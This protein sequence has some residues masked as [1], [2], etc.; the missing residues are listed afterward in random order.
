M[1]QGER[2]EFVGGMESISKLQATLFD[3]LSPPPTLRILTPSRG[4]FPAPSLRKSHSLCSTHT[5]RLALYL[6]GSLP[7][8]RQRARLEY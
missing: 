1:D 3:P 7:F 6:S 4:L 2:G 5:A 8:G